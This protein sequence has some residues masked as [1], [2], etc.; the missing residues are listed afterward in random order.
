[1]LPNSLL[2]QMFRFI[3]KICWVLCDFAK[4]YFLLRKKEILEK[5]N[6]VEFLP[7]TG[8][9]TAHPFGTR[10]KRYNN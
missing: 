9:I 4:K 7:P 10:L 8:Q 2:D 6:Y 3:G 1:M 5:S